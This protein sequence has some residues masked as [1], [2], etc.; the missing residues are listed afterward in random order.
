MKQYSIFPRYFTY[1]RRLLCLLQSWALYSCPYCV[2]SLIQLMVVC[3]W[4]TVFSYF[5][6]ICPFDQ[7]LVT[8]VC[9]PLFQTPGTLRMD[10]RP[11]LGNLLRT[12][13][14]YL[15]GNIHYDLKFVI[16]RTS[17]VLSQLSKTTHI[18]YQV[19]FIYLSKANNI[20]TASDSQSRG[21]FKGN[22]P[23]SFS[24]PPFGA[25]D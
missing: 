5:L 3:E 14:I 9:P 10:Q 22:I 8:P 2:L 1:Y 21:K 7:I 11:L 18:F 16:P 20:K 4:G 13:L 12:H 24:F 6:C 19:Y 17:E 15:P 23:C 25:G